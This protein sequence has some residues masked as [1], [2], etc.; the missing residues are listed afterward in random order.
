TTVSTDISANATP[1]GSGTPTGT[2]T[3]PG[4]HRS[5]TVVARRNWDVDSC[6]FHGR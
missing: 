5:G 1:L 2:V 3:V 4:R 6:P